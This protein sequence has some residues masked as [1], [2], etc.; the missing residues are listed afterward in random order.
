MKINYNFLYNIYL[1][2]Y[3]VFKV[4]MTCNKFYKEDGRIYCY[5][6]TFGFEIDLLHKI[7][8]NLNRSIS[9]KYSIRISQCASCLHFTIRPVKI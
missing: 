1:C 4:A 8:V 3:F 6:K 7:D 9:F 5:R 2:V